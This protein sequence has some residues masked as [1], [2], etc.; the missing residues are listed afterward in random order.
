MLAV[1]IALEIR[2]ATPAT[3]ADESYR[4]AQGPSRGHRAASRGSHVLAPQQTG[5][6]REPQASAVLS[7]DTRDLAMSFR[8]LGY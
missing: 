7:T 8:K 3:S 5:T 2:A 6:Y 1:V 4:P